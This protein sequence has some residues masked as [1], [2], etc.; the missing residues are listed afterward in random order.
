MGT[1]CRRH[2][3]VALPAGA[4]RGA[5]AG[6]TSSA[7]S[8]AGFTPINQMRLRM[9]VAAMAREMLGSGVSR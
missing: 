6:P 1:R 9:R 7:S 5:V 4:K 8:T 3:G 2:S